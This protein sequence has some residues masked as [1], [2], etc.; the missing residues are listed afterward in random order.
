MP[1]IPDPKTAPVVVEVQNAV[2]VLRL[3]RPA[4]HNAINIDVMVGLEEALDTLDRRRDVRVIVLTGA[5]ERSFCAGADLKDIARLESRGDGQTMS[6]R[7]KAILSRLADGRRPVI[8]AINGNTLGGGCEVLLA[9][10]LRIAAAAARFSF[11][12]AAMGVVTGWGGT[13]RAVRLLGRGRAL[14]LLLTAETLDASEALRLG[15]VDAVVESPD[16]LMDEALGLA[17]S[18]SANAESSVSAFLEL[19]RTYELEGVA[20]AD[21]RE[22]ELFSDCWV[23]DPFRRRVAEWAAKTDKPQ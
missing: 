18:I 12:Q 10:H 16:R 23:G 13:T 20:A 14:R 8:A 9:C 19:V 15:L 22:T 3:N 4:V 11:R 6:R 21:D 1:P 7:M 5:G 17:R 2:A